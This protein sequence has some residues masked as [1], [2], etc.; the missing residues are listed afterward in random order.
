MNK[1]CKDCHVR[2]NMHKCPGKTGEFK[3]CYRNCGHFKS[4]EICPIKNIEDIRDL[5]IIPEFID[6]EKPIRIKDYIDG[7]KLVSAF[8]AYDDLIEYIPIGYLVY[9]EKYINEIMEEI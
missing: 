9:D 3:F 8:Y 7:T 4:K 1:I 6:R 5:K 2:L